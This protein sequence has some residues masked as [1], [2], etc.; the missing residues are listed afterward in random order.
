MF[1]INKVHATAAALLLGGLG[2]K[3]LVAEPQ[4][5]SN[6]PTDATIKASRDEARDLSLALSAL[7]S[8]SNGDF[9]KYSLQPFYLGQTPIDD[10]LSRL[11]SAEKVLTRAQ[12]ALS[13]FR[14]EYLKQVEA[15]TER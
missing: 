4:D 2:M 12:S 5:A 9:S 11:E 14:D 3:Q 1:Q 15:S 10:T 13:E 7:D 8:L 6:Y